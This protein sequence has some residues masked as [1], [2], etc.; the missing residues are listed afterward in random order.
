MSDLNTLLHEATKDML[1]ARAAGDHD[2]LQAALA[3]CDAITELT[4]NRAEQQV[5]LGLI[6]EETAAVDAL[7][8]REKELLPAAG[9]KQRRGRRK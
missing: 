1:A 5:R 4:D 8:E 6:E 3:R 9:V 7:R 2:A